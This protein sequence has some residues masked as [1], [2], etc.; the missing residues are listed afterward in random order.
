MARRAATLTM[1]GYIFLPDS[2]DIG[3][4]D[5]FQLSGEGRRNGEFGVLPLNKFQHGPGVMAVAEDAPSVRV[6]LTPALAST[7]EQQ[8]AVRAPGGLPNMPSP[9]SVVRPP[10]AR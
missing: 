7:A 4:T 8:A 6:C 5:V 10:P 3:V 9:P 1:C 2:V